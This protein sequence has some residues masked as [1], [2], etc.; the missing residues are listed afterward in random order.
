MTDTT[1]KKID[2]SASP[3]GAMGQKYLAAGKNMSMRMWDE[4]APKDDK[5]PRRR[6]YETVGFVIEGHAQLEVEGQT[7]DLRPGDSWVVPAGA[8]HTYRILETFTAVEATSPPAAVHGR[9]EGNS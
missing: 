7:A 9:D 8:K 6:D 1:I 5:E 3:V 2:S 4:V